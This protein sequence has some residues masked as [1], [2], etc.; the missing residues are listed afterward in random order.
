MHFSPVADNFWHQLK[1][2]DHDDDD[3]TFDNNDD[4]DEDDNYQGGENDRK[5]HSW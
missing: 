5:K 1:L 2:C 3:D 4:G